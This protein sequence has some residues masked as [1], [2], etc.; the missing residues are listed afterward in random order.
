MAVSLSIDVNA[1]KY[2]P[3][4]PY[5]SISIKATQCSVCNGSD[6]CLKI[7]CSGYRPSANCVTSRRGLQKVAAPARLTDSNINKAID[8]LEKLAAA[9]QGSA[10]DSLPNLSRATAMTTL[11]LR[12]PTWTDMLRSAGRKASTR[13]RISD[14]YYAQLMY[15]VASE[16]GGALQHDRKSSPAVDS[17]GQPWAKV[18]DG[19]G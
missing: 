17:V 16:V 13:Q 9:R 12:P 15:L 4:I 6:G 3:D 5:Y 19:H 10:H 18:S 7:K 2:G 14:V 1:F 8:A 11:T